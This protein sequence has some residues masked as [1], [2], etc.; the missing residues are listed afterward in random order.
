M[1]IKQYGPTENKNEIL[2]VPRRQ[3]DCEKKYKKRKEN[4]LFPKM[5]L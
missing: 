3:C 4:E 1:T 5:P 2:V